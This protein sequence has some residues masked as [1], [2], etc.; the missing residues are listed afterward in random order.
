M[1]TNLPLIRG[2]RRLVRDSSGATALIFTFTLPVMLGFAGL[3]IEVG[4]WLL[5]Q[6]AMQGAADTAAISAATALALNAISSPANPCFSGTTDICTNE[7]ISVAAMNGWT[8]GNGV[9]VTAHNPP[10]SGQYAGNNAAVQVVITRTGTNWFSAFLPGGYAAPT[11]AAGSVALAQPGIDCMLS[12]DQ[13]TAT[14][15]SFLLADVPLIGPGINMPNCSIGVN[16][17]NPLAALSWVGDVPVNAYSATVVGGI[18]PPLNLPLGLGF[19]WTKTPVSGPAPPGP[20]TPDPYVCPGNQC[21]PM[22]QPTLPGWLT[23]PAAMTVPGPATTCNGPTITTS[24]AIPAGCSK[25]IVASGNLTLSAN[26]CTSG[27]PCVIMSPFTDSPVLD[28]RGRPVQPPR[29]TR[30]YNGPAIN[31]TGGL[32]ISGTGYLTILGGPGQPGI[33][34]S[35]SGNV[36]INTHTNVI[37]GGGS[38]GAAISVN[39]GNLRINSV[40]NTIMGGPNG[41]G[42]QGI[43]IS[44][45]GNVTI[46]ATTNTIQGGTGGTSSNN[47]A[48]RLSGGQPVLTFGPSTNRIIGGPGSS[49]IVVNPLAGSDG[50]YGQL[51][52]GNGNN[53]IQG[54]QA[55]AGSHPAMTIGGFGHVVFGN[56]IG[57]FGGP[58]VRP[59]IPAVYDNTLFAFGSQRGL[60]LG[61]GSYTFM[62]GISITGGDLTLN[63]SGSS[64]GY[65]IMVGGGT[66]SLFGSGFNMTAGNLIGSNVTIVLTGGTADNIGASDYANINYVGANGISLTAPTTGPTAGIAIFQDRSAVTPNPNTFSGGTFGNITG[67]IYTPNQPIVFDGIGHM[68]SRCLQMIAST[69]TIAGIIYMNDDCQGTGTSPIVSN[70]SIVLVQ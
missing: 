62:E 2:L 55:D 36:T 40:A 35:G 46:D 16:S 69:I 33:S 25:G 21:R 28:R 58:R 29:T 31:A 67:A 39:S 9:T 30:T 26:Q 34:V 10:V 60:T 44:G 37:Q 53:Y 1:A 48:I 38:G 13:S 63:P 49:A 8:S 66:P 22:P 17:T 6:R 65:Y 64:V 14:G 56:G 18:F 12:L 3:A 68:N 32:T 51:T 7:A 50:S 15:V 20:P 42:T 57:V 24:G 43:R 61:S 27:S 4:S 54:A 47:A 70:G 41:S 45:T 19:N 59:G 52:F 11:L 5:S 23:P